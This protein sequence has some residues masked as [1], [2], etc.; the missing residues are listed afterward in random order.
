M[1]GSVDFG[2]TNGFA[3][4]ILDGKYGCGFQYLTPKAV[5]SKP[6]LDDY[7]S[8]AEYFAN[9]NII[10]KIGVVTYHLHTTVSPYSLQKIVLDTYNK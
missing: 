10:N 9:H 5:M 8:S 2:N 6:F 3:D 7:I 1:V 4:R